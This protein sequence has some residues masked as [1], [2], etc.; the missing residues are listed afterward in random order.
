MVLLVLC[1]IQVR[2]PRVL[3]LEARGL[4]V[5][6]GVRWFVSLW[7]CEKWLFV[8]S[9]FKDR[10]CGRGRLVYLELEET[11][12]DDNREGAAAARGRGEAHA[13]QQQPELTL[14]GVEGSFALLG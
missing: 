3:R 2:E 14:T 9:S 4:I 12:A 10:L 8:R 7:F 5:T 13:Q 6:I 1:W 11:P